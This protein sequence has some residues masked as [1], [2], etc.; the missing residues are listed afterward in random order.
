MYENSKYSPN[1]SADVRWVAVSFYMWRNI[2]DMGTVFRPHDPFGVVLIATWFG[3]L[4]DKRN[5]VP[6]IP[7]C[8]FSNVALTSFVLWSPFHIGDTETPYLGYEP[9]KKEKSDFFF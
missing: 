2:L 4:F 8:E 6:D 3:T 7:R 9:V 1:V 5:I